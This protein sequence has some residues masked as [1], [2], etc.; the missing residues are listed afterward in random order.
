VLLLILNFIGLGLGPLIVGGLSQ[1]VFAGAG[2]HSLRYALA[3]I[4]LIG[5]WG[6][7]HY[8]LAGKELVRPSSVAG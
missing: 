2:E 5:I 4:Q 6:A 7:L 8:Y 1:W 3:T